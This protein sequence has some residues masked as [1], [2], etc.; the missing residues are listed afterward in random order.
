[1]LLFFHDIE[2]LTEC[3]RD[4]CLLAWSV[5]FGS[6]SKLEVLVRLALE[7]VYFHFSYA[8]YSVFV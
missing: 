7:K 5:Q 6:R 1:M 3:V 4:D 8:N 2:A